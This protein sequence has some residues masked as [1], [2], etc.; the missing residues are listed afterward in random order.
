MSEDVWEQH[1]QAMLKRLY[2]TGGVIGKYGIDYIVLKL[3]EKDNVALGKIYFEE[4]TI[5]NKLR[6][7]EAVYDV[8]DDQGKRQLLGFFKQASDFDEEE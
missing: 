7:L 1:K 5:R 8:A 3:L 4:Y 2:E 6:D